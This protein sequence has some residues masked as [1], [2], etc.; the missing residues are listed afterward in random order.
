V[1][2][3][4]VWLLLLLLIAA[5]IW[6][7][8]RRVIRGR[9]TPRELPACGACGYCLRG[10]QTHHCP[11]CGSALIEVGII[12]SGARQQKGALSPAVA[13]SILCLVG[14]L[15]IGIPISTVLPRSSITRGRQV[16]TLQQPSSGSHSAVTFTQDFESRGG[17]VDAPITVALRGAPG[18]PDQVI[19]LV[20]DP[21]AER[22]RIARDAGS[23]D[24][25]LPLTRSTTLRWLDQNQVGGSDAMVVAEADA[26][27]VALADA[28]W[29]TVDVGGNWSSSSDRGE[30]TGAYSRKTMSSQGRTTWQPAWYHLPL[31][32]LAFCVWLG[33]VFIIIRRSAAPNQTAS[34]AGP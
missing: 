5:L 26:I 31:H 33:G 4:F 30:S 32:L 13:W 18:S 6:M 21:K 10:L 7:I 1:I 20:V 8:T 12:A 2:F 25:H 19:R 16:M 27:L 34:S 15:L 17:E 14:Y 9:G 22:A 3:S 11:E 28:D 23:I 24:E 29:T